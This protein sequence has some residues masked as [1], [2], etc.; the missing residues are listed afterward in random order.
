MDLATSTDNSTLENNSNTANTSI[1]TEDTTINSI[2]F[3]EI[4]SKVDLLLPDSPIAKLF[5][6]INWDTPLRFPA[7]DDACLNEASSQDKMIDLSPILTEHQIVDCA[8]PSNDDDCADD[9]D[10]DLTGQ[11][12]GS[13][14]KGL[15]IYDLEADEMYKTIKMLRI[16]K[17]VDDEIGS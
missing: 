11:D 16:V 2:S 4:S 17:D 7:Q 15:S 3:E 12:G 13:I 8:L 10:D 9:G 6:R 1:A 5:N 14:A